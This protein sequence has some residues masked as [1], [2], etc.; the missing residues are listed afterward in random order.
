MEPI[1]R[2]VASSGSSRPVI[3]GFGGIYDPNTVTAYSV[4]F[5]LGVQR[6]MAQNLVLQADFVMRRSMHFGGLHNAFIYDRNR[7]DR[8]RVITVHP[9]TGRGNPNPNPIIPRCAAAQ[10]LDPK[11]QCSQGIISV[12]GT[13]AKLPLHRPSHQVRPAILNPFYLFT[14]SYALSKYTG[15]NGFGNGAVSL[16]D[17]FAGDG[18]QGL[19]PPPSLHLQRHCRGAEV[20]RR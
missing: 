17:H 6:E 8:A 9:V 18:Y 16:D 14:A 3:A 11:A 20:W 19:R 10:A 15:F 7:Y 12:S 4:N 5:G 13:S 2:C 1:F